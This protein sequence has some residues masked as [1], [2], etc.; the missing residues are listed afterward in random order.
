M[1]SSARTLIITIHPFVM[2]IPEGGGGGRI[3]ATNL[4]IQLDTTPVA[5]AA[6]TSKLK[7]Y[8]ATTLPQKLQ[9]WLIILLS[10]SSLMSSF[11]STAT[12]MWKFPYNCTCGG[13]N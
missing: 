9:L 2:D 13:G 4:D 12:G 7:I 3:R 10:A 1:L 6:E 8:Q 11:V 5:A